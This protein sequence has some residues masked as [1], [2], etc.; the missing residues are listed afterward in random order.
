MEVMESSELEVIGS[1]G[2]CGMSTCQSCTE[3]GVR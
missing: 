1:K 2:A 3:R